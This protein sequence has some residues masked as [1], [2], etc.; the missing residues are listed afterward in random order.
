MCANIFP[1]GEILFDSSM[2]DGNPRKLMD[3]TKL[4][5]LGWKPQTNLK[6]GL[7]KTYTWYLENI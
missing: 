1:D 5:S 2:P 7:I 4:Y 3:S 6:E